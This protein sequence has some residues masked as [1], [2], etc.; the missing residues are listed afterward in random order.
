MGAFIGDKARNTAIVLMLF[1]LLLAVYIGQQGGIEG[2]FHSEYET[3]DLAEYIKQ[4]CKSRN[5]AIITGDVTMIEPLYDRSTKYGAW[6]YQHEI[7]KMKY[8]QNWGQKQGVKFTEIIP[9]IKVRSIKPKDDRV[10]VNLMCSTEYRYVY[11][12]E[13]GIVNSSRIGTYHVLDLLYK[14]EAWVITREWYKDP[15][16]DILNLGRIKVDSINQFI[17]AHAPRDLANI[18]ERRKNAVLYA[19]RYCGAASEEKYGFQYNKKY[20]NYN[21]QGGDCANFVSQVLYEGGKFRKNHMWNYNGKGATRAWLN[22]DGFKNYMLH[23][24]RASLIAY[25]NYEKVYK[26]S[27][28]LLPGDFI[29]YEKGG[30]ITHISVVTGADS[31][32]Y[33][34]VTCHN[35]DR[36][37]VP[38]DLGWSSTKVRFWLVRVHY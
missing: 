12:N 33:S 6:A 23:S 30:D 9:T 3:E 26:A 11:E 29:A 34:L 20:R 13:P 15:F 38:W 27:Y 1:L 14:D 17:S 36:Y 31:K 10:T 24:G 19:E 35:T 32:G 21:S 2:V 8:V 16:E 28:K 37:N 25:G 18:D 4:M 22:A 7:T 5:N